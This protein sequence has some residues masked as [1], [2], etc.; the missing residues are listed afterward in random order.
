MKTLLWLDDI[1][2]PLE[3]DWLAFSP[4][5]K[6][7]KLVWVKSYKEFTQWILK[8]GLPE[9]ICFDHDLGDEYHWKETEEITPGTLL[10]T[11]HEI[12]YE[13]FK[14]ELTGYHCAQWLINYH[15]NN[16][17]F[18]EFTFP[19]WNI[20]SANSVGAENIKSVLN[21]YKKELFG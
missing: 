13:D 20:Q 16:R 7:Y 14:N 19:K 11:Q 3:E 15:I 17:A 8:N 21:Q 6:P 4:I 1:R 5:S 9:G 2:D 10:P 18:Y 12:L